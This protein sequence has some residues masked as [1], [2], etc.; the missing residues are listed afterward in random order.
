MNK[1]AIKVKHS[2]HTPILKLIKKSYVSGRGVGRGRC[3]LC[4]GHDLSR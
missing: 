3:K 2:P 4:P 1:I